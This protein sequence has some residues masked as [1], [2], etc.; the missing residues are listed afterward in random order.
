MEIG[1]LKNME[2]RLN[3]PVSLGLHFTFLQWCDRAT[4]V[5]IHI[6]SGEL[7]SSKLSSSCEIDV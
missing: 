5:T 7:E 3:M 4:S 2:T 1:H 6:I